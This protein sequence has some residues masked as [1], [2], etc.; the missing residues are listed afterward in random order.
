MHTL[1]VRNIH[2]EKEKRNLGTLRQIN[3][4]ESIVTQTYLFAENDVC[5]YDEHRL[6][7]GKSNK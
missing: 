6:Q 4:S 3:N 5:N 7:A 2:R 1:M